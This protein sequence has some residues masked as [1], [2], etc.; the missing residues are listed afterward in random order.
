VHSSPLEPAFRIPYGVVL[1]LAK[2]PHDPEELAVGHLVQTDEEGLVELQAVVEE[3]S[4]LN[5]YLYLVGK[6]A[7]I[8]TF[9]IKL[10]DEWEEPGEEEIYVNNALSDKA[11]IETFLSEN[12]LDTVLNGYVT[13]T[14]YSDLGETN[15]NISDHKMIVIMS[16]EG[17]LVEQMSLALEE[18][19][20]PRQREM[21]MV[22]CEFHHW[23]FRHPKSKSRA[24]LVEWLEENRFTKWDPNFS[25]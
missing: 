16:Y 21:A 15:L 8:E 14:T 9:W 4:L 6:L 20:V 5:V 13:I 10:H 1:S 17:A 24:E 22:S 3:A 12:L 11:R 25:E 18:Q 7:D 2:G 23:H 19:G